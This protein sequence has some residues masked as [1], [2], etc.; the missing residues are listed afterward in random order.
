[1]QDRTIAGAHCKQGG[2]R[3]QQP[4]GPRKS[5]RGSIAFLGPTERVAARNGEGSAGGGNHGAVRQFAGWAW[6]RVY[7]FMAT[8]QLLG[9]QLCIHLVS[10]RDA[11]S[12]PRGPGVAERLGI[13]PTAIKA[14]PVTSGQRYGFV[15]EEELRPTVGPHHL[16]PPSFIVEDANQPRLGR[17]A[18][19]EQ[20]FRRRVVDDAAVTN[21]CAPLRPPAAT[22]W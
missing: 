5:L 2:R 1:V 4:I 8:F 21:E 11:P 22:R 15:R 17:P 10:Q 20:G 3:G 16:A 6:Y 9:V 12:S 7:P 19:A 14:R 18:P 13:L